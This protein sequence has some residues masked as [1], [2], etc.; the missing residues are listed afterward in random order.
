MKIVLADDTGGK[1]ASTLLNHLLEFV[2]RFSSLHW[3]WLA[4]FRNFH[5]RFFVNSPKARRKTI[6]Q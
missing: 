5:R 1:I 4:F 2:A 3:N 6:H